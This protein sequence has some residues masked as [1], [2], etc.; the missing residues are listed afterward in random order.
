MS[1]KLG[2]SWG[3]IGSQ[4]GFTWGTGLFLSFGQVTLARIGREGS[5][6]KG[7]GGAGGS[8]QSLAATGGHR[9]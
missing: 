1:R 9:P 2:W 8:V 3:A 6:H 5:T 4:Q 7:V